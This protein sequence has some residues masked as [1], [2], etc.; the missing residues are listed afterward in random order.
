MIK[1]TLKYLY[2]AAKNPQKQGRILEGG[3]ENF[4]GWPEFIL[5]TPVSDGNIIL[6]M[7]EHVFDVFDIFPDS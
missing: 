7:G 2:E 5:Y 1:H 4:S 6:L 3:G